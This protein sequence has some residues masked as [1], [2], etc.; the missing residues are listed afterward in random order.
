MKL[1]YFYFFKEQFHPTPW[2][3]ITRQITKSLYETFH[4]CLHVIV[5]NLGKAALFCQQT[6][7]MFILCAVLVSAIDLP[8]GCFL[9]AVSSTLTLI[10]VGQ[11]FWRIGTGMEVTISKLLDCNESCSS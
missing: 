4:L 6:L 1:P 10:Q 7:C 8:S 5:K 11:C 2:C 3:S 9:D